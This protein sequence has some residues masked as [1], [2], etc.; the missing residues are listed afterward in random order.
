MPLKRSDEF[1][2]DF[3]SDE[4]VDENIKQ[5]TG[6]SVNEEKHN[7]FAKLEQRMNIMSGSTK[8]PS[9]KEIKEIKNDII[10]AID[11]TKEIIRSDEDTFED[12]RFIQEKLKCAI[13]KVESQMDNLEQSLLIGAESRLWETY[14][15]MAKTLFGGLRDLMDL[16]KMVQMTL[17]SQNQLQETTINKG[18]VVFEEKVTRKISASNFQDVLDELH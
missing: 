8:L 2:S 9:K 1:L 12:K 17:I 3:L 7:P 6:L 15:I 13:I 14:S 10:E 16:Q 5:N 11:D 4:Q 18:G